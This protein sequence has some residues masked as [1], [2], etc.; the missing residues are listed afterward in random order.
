MREA[1]AAD[2]EG[3]TG[4][5]ERVVVTTVSL[6]RMLTRAEAAT[7]LDVSARTVTELVRRGQL[8]AYRFGGRPRFLPADVVALRDAR[9][10]QAQHVA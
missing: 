5:S 1:E 8:P 9:S 2:G 3:Q 7:Q 10:A 4:G 6:G